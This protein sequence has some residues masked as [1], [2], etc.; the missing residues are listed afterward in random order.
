MNFVF[1][2]T[3]ISLNQL[4]VLLK[5]LMANKFL[6]H[7]KINRRGCYFKATWQLI[8]AEANKHGVKYSS[9]NLGRVG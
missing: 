7:N 3:E 6:I 2:R 9:E 5:G 4:D 8:A 1:P